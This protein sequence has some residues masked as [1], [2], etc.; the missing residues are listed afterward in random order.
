MQMAL[1]ANYYSNDYL[2]YYT[3]YYYYSMLLLL[4]IIGTYIWAQ[5]KFDA[6]LIR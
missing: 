2:Y 4:I 3:G 1:L 5:D 6:I